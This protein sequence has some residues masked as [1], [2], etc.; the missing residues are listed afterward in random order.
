M[1]GEFLPLPM[2]A[3]VAYLRLVSHEDRGPASEGLLDVVASALSI[4]VP[5]YGGEPRV[6][7]DDELVARGRLCNGA[8]RLRFRDGT[9]PLEN[10]AILQPDLEA[11]I[12]RLE[13]AGVRF[14]DAMLEQAPRRVPRV[15]PSTT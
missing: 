11:G 2:A 6:R 8:T 13:C 3:A 14:S 9:P 12:R 10:L 5:L 7:L 1:S 4:W 15:L